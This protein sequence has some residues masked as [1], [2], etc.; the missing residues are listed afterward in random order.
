MNY[1]WFIDPNRN[2]KFSKLNNLELQELLKAL[3]NFYLIYREKLD[4]P[5][6]VSFGVE[7]EYQNLSNELIE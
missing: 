2:D 3:D 5:E 4:L 1:L 7:L 6:T